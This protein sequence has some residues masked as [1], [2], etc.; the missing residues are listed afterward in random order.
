MLDAS[1]NHASILTWGF[2]NEGPSDNPVA[3]D[4]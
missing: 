1:R 4:A 3:C 2:F